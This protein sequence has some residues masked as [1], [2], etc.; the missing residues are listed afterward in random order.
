VAIVV[1]HRNR[2]DHLHRFFAHLMAL[3][4]RGFELDVYV[5][6]QDD[7]A[8]FNRGLMLNI[9]FGIAHA[10]RKYRRFIFHDVD[11]YP[12]QTMYDYY[13]AYLEKAMHFAS[14][15]LGYKYHYDQF[16]GGVAGMSERDFKR[17][18]GFPNDFFGWGGEDNAFRVRCAQARIA[19]FR[20]STGAYDTPEHADPT[21]AE[22]ND[23]RRAQCVRDRTSWRENG[24]AQIPALPLHFTYFR[25]DEFFAGY[26]EP[27][28]T[29]G[30]DARV[31]P[32]RCVVS[33]GIGAYFCKVRSVVA[34]LQN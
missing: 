18:N 3:D 7:R 10:L 20:P 6:D 31:A 32:V 2:L 28:A 27:R 34:A 24:V 22:Y 4:A 5:I 25:Q 23:D 11:S 13:F 16:M 17:V 26:G 1:P 19:V 14:P 21:E 30:E 29:E 9:G 33:T 8:K 15:A 12:D